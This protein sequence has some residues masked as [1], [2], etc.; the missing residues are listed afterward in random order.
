MDKIARLPKNKIYLLLVACAVVIFAAS[1][2]VLFLVKDSEMY[3][4]WARTMREIQPDQPIA[5]FSF[6]HYVASNLFQY[7]LRILTPMVFGIHSYF[8]YLKLGINNLFVFIWAVLLAGGAAYAL[9][10]ANV[11]SVFF[12]LIMAGY[13]ILF[14]TVLSLHD[15][16]SSFRTPDTSR[17]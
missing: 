7:F 13:L 8:A 9:I 10:G 12:Y 3:A 1:M 14:I 15:N 4:L 11:Y 5:Q 16:I 6:D 2:E 17:R